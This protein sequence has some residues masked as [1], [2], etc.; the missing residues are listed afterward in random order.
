MIGNPPFGDVDIKYAG[1]KRP[2]HDFFFAKG[3]DTL[4]PGGVLALI[5]S[6]FTLDKLNASTREYLADRADFLGAIRLPS[7]AFKGQGTDVV[8]DIVFLRRRAPGQEPN[9]ADPE[10][11]RTTPLGIAGLDV[12]INRYFRNR[13][14]MVLGDWSRKDTL[15]ASGISL[16]ANGDL[17]S[18]LKEA[19]A[20]LPQ[21]QVVASEAGR[22]N[23]PPVTAS[24]AFV[25]PPAERHIA[26]GSFFVGDDRVIRQVE[27]GR[28]EPVTYCGVLLRADGTPNGRKIGALIGLRDLARRVLRSQNEGWP[29]GHRDEARRALNRAY[30]RF[31]AAYGPIN[32]T[33]F[34]ATKDGTVIRVACPTP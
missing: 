14:E 19:I 22:A 27:D 25:P 33:S 31:V 1:E 12:S 10:W 28:A 13:P 15:H 23:P 21:G 20:R 30:D 26:E 24:P 2:I 8:T 3:V 29:E 16:T 4:K 18:Q 5:T 11:L 6:R 32:K 34:A 7:N 9:H 17:A